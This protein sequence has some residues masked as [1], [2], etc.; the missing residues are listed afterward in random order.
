[1]CQLFSSYLTNIKG[2]NTKV[3]PCALSFY[4]LCNWYLLEILSIAEKIYV[5]GYH[6]S[7]YVERCGKWV[8]SVHNVGLYRYVTGKF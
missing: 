5:L 6:H 7:L 3:I 1:M 2:A 8:K 4:C